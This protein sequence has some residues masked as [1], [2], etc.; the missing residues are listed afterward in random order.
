MKR[1]LRYSALL[2]IVLAG[3][4][5]TSCAPSAPS[6]ESSSASSGSTA[7]KSSGAKS[8]V[9]IRNDFYRAIV[10]RL[11]GPEKREITV[12]ARSSRSLEVKAGIYKYATAAEG[13]R[14]ISRYKVM[15][16]GRRYRLYF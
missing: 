13:F 14:P 1:L 3:L 5:A 7:L 16:A 6:S 8:H 4:S 12:P 9:K 15:E 11:E 10:V 2:A